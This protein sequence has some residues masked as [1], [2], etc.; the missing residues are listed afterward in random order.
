MALSQT[1]YARSAHA[2]HASD[3]R[4]M[5]PW[6]DRRSTQFGLSVA[7]PESTQAPEPK[8]SLPASAPSLRGTAN[9]LRARN[10]ASVIARRPNLRGA[11]AKAASVV[12]ET[13]PEEDWSATVDPSPA[14]QHTR[15]DDH[16]DQDTPNNRRAR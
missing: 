1:A 14:Q 6:E 3:D 12:Q 13:P 5:P 8:A 4:S 9:G 11:I 16:V 10:A 7:T 15:D 2:V